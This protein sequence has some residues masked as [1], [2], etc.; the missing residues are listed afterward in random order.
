MGA[1]CSHELRPK[2]DPSR[3][4]PPAAIWRI[5]RSDDPEREVAP[6]ADFLRLPPVTQKLIAGMAPTA[7]QRA[8]AFANSD[9]VR[10]Y[11]P[12]KPEEVRP[13]IDAEIAA[14]VVPLYGLTGPSGPG[15][16]AL[17]F[18]LEVR[19]LDLRHW[20]EGTLLCE[21]APPASPFRSGEHYPLSSIPS[22]AAAFTRDRDWK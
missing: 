19:T 4:V 8:L 13:F 21:K 9:R 15:R 16:M 18:V 22:V 14:G 5:V 11:Y 20:R 1:F 12:R 6:Y 3:P 7:G 10:E 2:P 17:D